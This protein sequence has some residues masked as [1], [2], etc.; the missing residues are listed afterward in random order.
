LTIFFGEKW[1]LL[2]TG[3]FPHKFRSIIFL[4]FH[5]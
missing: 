5:L 3:R 2:S 4:L 1:I